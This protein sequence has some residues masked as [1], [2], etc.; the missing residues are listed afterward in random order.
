M[1]MD[2]QTGSERHILEG[3]L[4]SNRAT[5]V[6]K[7]DGLTWEQATQRL[8]PTPTSMAGVVKHLI[9]VE[10][11]WFRHI[12]AGEAEVPFDWSDDAP[13]VEFAFAPQDSLESLITA[14]EAAC[15][16]ARKVAERYDLTD[17]AARGWRGQR[18]PS[19]R[20]IYVHM[21]EELARHNG[22][23]DIYRELLDGQTDRD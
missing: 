8:G 17:Q 2:E 11:W 9:N 19:L 15:A 20:W 18:H 7:V 13:D 22:H 10:R 3:H 5:V 21:I 23:L 4:E 16:E 6:R 14:Y 12:L 1:T